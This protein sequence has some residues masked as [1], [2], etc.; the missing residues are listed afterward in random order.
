MSSWL[1]NI[2]GWGSSSTQ[3]PLPAKKNDN[4]V[5]LPQEGRTGD[6]VSV[7]LVEED[8]SRLTVSS[9][10]GANEFSN[11]DSGSS[12]QVKIVNR[13]QDAPKE[14]S[15]TF[16]LDNL[17]D[18]ADH[19]EITANTRGDISCKEFDKDPKDKIPS[20]LDRFRRAAN[21][22]LAQKEAYH[23]GIMQVRDL[24][25]QEYDDNAAERFNNYFS[26]RIWAK[27]PLTVRALKEFIDQE[28]E[29][30]LG[31]VNISTIA[32]KAG[33]L[34]DLKREL[35]SKK[36]EGGHHIIGGDKVPSP[37]EKT[38]FLSIKHS[39]FERAEDA[40]RRKGREAGV[41]E[42]RTA[43][44]DLIQDP[45][46]KSHVEHLFDSHFAVKIEKKETLTVKELSTFIDAA[47]KI[48]DSEN[49]MLGGLYSA[50]RT[51]KDSGEDVSAAVYKF[52][53]TAYHDLGLAAG[54]AVVLDQE[55]N[56]NDPIMGLIKGLAAG[57][58]VA[59]EN[60]TERILTLAAEHLLPAAAPASQTSI[61]SSVLKWFTF[62]IY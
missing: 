42:A 4:P 9:S 52:F 47:I 45:T 62:G 23:R 27:K 60:D 51:A 49:G 2:F 33:S 36:S 20:T 50:A 31:E 3:A 15:K 26:Y 35:P 24:L 30:R 46:T 44:L 59:S 18:F 61:T 55:R 39:W 43:I 11:V 37:P 38:Y 56:T 41:S 58:L 10:S 29:L 13:N 21:R 1:G 40:D 5:S 48:R 28:N 54:A 7:T 14:Q 57:T 6:G 32:T 25:I 17:D 8:R 22:T 16:S 34:E 19:F 53:K 12:H